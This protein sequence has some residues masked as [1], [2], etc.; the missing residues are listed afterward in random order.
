MVTIRLEESDNPNRIF[1][2]LNFRGKELAQSD[3]VRNFFMM[4]IREQ[5]STDDLYQQVWFPM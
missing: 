3:L 1:E 2:T 4:S 5:S